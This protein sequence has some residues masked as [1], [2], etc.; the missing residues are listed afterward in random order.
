M[1][2]L[3][4]GVGAVVLLA[5]TAVAQRRARVGPT[6]SWI[7]LRDASG[8]SHIYPSICGSIALLTGDDAESGITVS[9]YNDLAQGGSV[10]RLTVCVSD[11]FQ[12]PV[13][14]RGVSPR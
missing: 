12:Y 6:L 10:R 1:I 14:P 9:C 13:R 4:L 7:A 8:T 3:I 5:P 11:Y 2:L